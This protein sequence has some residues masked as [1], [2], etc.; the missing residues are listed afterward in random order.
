MSTSDNPQFTS[1]PRGIEKD[2]LVEAFLELEGV[3][4]KGLPDI[5]GAIGSTPAEK[6]YFEPA[7]G[8]FVL[9]VWGVGRWSTA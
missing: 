2:P 9:R 8:G 5:L 3:D 6:G 4:Q 1:D 7:I